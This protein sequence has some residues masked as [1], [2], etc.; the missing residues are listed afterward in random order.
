M[1]KLFIV[2]KI[3][4]GV[5]DMP[6]FEYHNIEVIEAESI[7]EA[8]EIYNQKNKRKNSDGKCIGKCDKETGWISM[9]MPI[10]KVLLNQ[11]NSYE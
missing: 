6:E 2:A 1:K 4:G 8:E 5:M 11:L 9:P 7:D 3:T 10:F